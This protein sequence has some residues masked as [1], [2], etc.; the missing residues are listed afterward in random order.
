[1]FE[2]TK[3]VRAPWIVRSAWGVAAAAT[4]LAALLIFGQNVMEL[5]DIDASLVS[6]PADDSTIF[7]TAVGERSTV[8]LSDSSTITLNTN[9]RVSVLFTHVSAI[10]R[11]KLERGQAHFE[12]E[13][14]PRRFEVLAGNRRIVAL[15]TAFDVRLDPEGQGVQVTLVEG[16][17]SVDEI[18]EGTAELGGPIDTSLPPSATEL[19]AGEQLITTSDE[20]PAVIEADIEQ[21]VGWR[22]GRLV[23]R[24]NPLADAVSEINRYSQTKLV[25]RND[26]RLEAIPISGVFETGRTATFLEAV[27]TLHPVKS[28]R[29]AFDRI[30]LFWLGEGVNFA[31]SEDEAGDVREAEPP[32]S[33]ANKGRD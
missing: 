19:E 23:F 2:E 27:E 32:T 30:E 8:T 3:S 5:P 33:T 13:K 14:D 22:E 9:S 29:V 1:M 25:V 15:G 24:G 12:V 4:I 6:V 26:E 21:V 31:G 7:E 16:R 18:I 10:R 11:V 17:V 20:A 28:Q